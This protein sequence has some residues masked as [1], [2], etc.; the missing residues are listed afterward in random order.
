MWKNS[1]SPMHLL[2]GFQSFD[3]DEG[4]S[5]VPQ[6]IVSEEKQSPSSKRV[7]LGQEKQF[8]MFKVGI[9]SEQVNKE[10]NSPAWKT[11]EVVVKPFYFPLSFVCE[12]PLNAKLTTT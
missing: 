3:M 10:C 12:A 5:D 8:A 1:T 7:K 9:S 6:N 4:S 2:T 11:N